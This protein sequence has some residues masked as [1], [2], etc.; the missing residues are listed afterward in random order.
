[1]P[2]ESSPMYRTTVRML[3]SSHTLRQLWFLRSTLR[4]E[5]A[6]QW[7]PERLMVGA[8]IAGILHG[9][10]R[11]DGSSA[12]LSISMPNTFSMSPA[13]VQKYIREKGLQAPQQDVF[14][15]LREACTSVP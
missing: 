2:A 3:F 1:M 5:R 10:T 4:P 13:Y 14:A 6:L 12:Y 7:S 15:R 8:C 9:A 11:K